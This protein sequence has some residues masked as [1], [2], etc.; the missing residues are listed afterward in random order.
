MCVC[1]CV[2][3]SCDYWV[4]EQ[5]NLS[6]LFVFSFLEHQQMNK[7]FRKF[8]FEGRNWVFL[9]QKVSRLLFVNL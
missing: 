3:C 2:L 1:V 6:V 9:G 5:S 7:Y 8:D 4:F